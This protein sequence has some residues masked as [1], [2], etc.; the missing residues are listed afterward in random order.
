MDVCVC[1]KKERCKSGIRIRRLNKGKVR[2]CEKSAK[3]L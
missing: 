3:L 1:V 2:K